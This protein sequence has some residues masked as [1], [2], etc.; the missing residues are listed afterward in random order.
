MEV[1]SRKTRTTGV[2]PLEVL[3]ALTRQD[4]LAEH[5]GEPCGPGWVGNPWLDLGFFRFRE[6]RPRPAHSLFRTLDAKPETRVLSRD[7]GVH[8]ERFPFWEIFSPP[9]GLGLAPGPLAD[10]GSYRTRGFHGVGTLGIPAGAGAAGPGFFRKTWRGPLGSG[11][12][13]G[14]A[15]GVCGPGNLGLQLG[16]GANLTFPLWG[17]GFNAAPGGFSPGA[18]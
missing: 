1:G 2:V 14:G 17:L 5:S 12:S 9:F 11:G 4:I 8:T 13:L 16:P 18:T 6:G 7:L 3:L 10:L 15:H